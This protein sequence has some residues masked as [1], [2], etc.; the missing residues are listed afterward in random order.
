[1]KKVLILIVLF[2]FFTLCSC[3][4][5]VITPRDENGKPIIIEKDPELINDVSEEKKL[6]I[7]VAALM[8]HYFN[9]D[10]DIANGAFEGVY[11]EEFENDLKYFKDNG[12]R[13]ITCSQLYAFVNGEIDLPEKCVM[14]TIDDGHYSVYKWV[15]PLLEKYDAYVNL[16]IIGDYATSLSQY[17]A[18]DKPRLNWMNWDEISEISK[19]SYVEIGSHTYGLHD[20]DNGRYGVLRNSSETK[21][22]YELMISNDSNRNNE[23][24]L[25]K[26]GYSPIFFAYPYSCPEKEYMEYM[27]NTFGY[28]VLLCGNSKNWSIKNYNCFMK[29]SKDE[30]IIIRRFSRYTND[31]IG[32]L[33]NSILD[34]VENELTLRGLG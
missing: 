5:V 21:A 2:L 24:I 11:P 13:T 23:N 22:E 33:I 3:V 4:T 12:I 20:K 34:N 28:K 29:D 9:T 25:D 15:V 1:M 26:C 7:K 30:N 17:R 8:Y 18:D 27:I 16:S 19:N 31:D 32:L 6:E 10:E 14:I